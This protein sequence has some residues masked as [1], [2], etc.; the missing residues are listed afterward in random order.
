[1]PKSQ[2]LQFI[3]Q[4]GSKTTDPI[5]KHKI[6]KHARSHVSRSKGVEKTA[7]LLQFQLIVPD[8]F[9]P[10]ASS[11]GIVAPDTGLSSGTD[12]SSGDG[13]VSQYSNCPARK[14]G[15]ESP[16]ESEV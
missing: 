15:Q 12:P 4:T 3:T 7:S 6:R 1:M 9:G 14:L 5:L 2:A 10:S 11:R 16:A 13:H 8:S